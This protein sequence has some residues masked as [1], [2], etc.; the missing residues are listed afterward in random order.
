MRK[1][2]LGV[3]AALLAGACFEDPV[4]VEPGMDG[5]ASGSG[6]GT[7]PTTHTAT[8]PDTDAPPTTME[9]V[10][11]SVDDTAAPDESSTGEPLPVQCGDGT[12]V[13]GELCYD[14][15]TVLMAN[16]VTF[17]ARIGDVSS[18][19]ATDVVHLISDQVVVRAGNGS[20]NFGPAVFDASVVA[21]RFELVDFDGDGE[22]DVLAAETSGRLH[23]L[24]GTGAGSFA[25][26]D[27][28]S[29]GPDPQALAV[30]DLDGDGALDAVVGSGT[31]IHV[32]LGDG[33]GGLGPGTSLVGTSPVTGLSLGDVDGDAVLDLALAI[34]GGDGQGVVLRRGVGDGTFA[35]Q[36]ATPGRLGGA[37]AIVAGDLDGDGATDLAYVSQ[38]SQVVG[39]LLG[40]EDGLGPEL[41][42]PTG[43]GPQ[44]LHAADLDGDG[45]L[46]LVV[47]HQGETT[48][49]VFTVSAGGVAEALQIPLASPATALHSG[50]VNG[51][52]VPDLAATSSAAH[53][54]T[55]VLSTP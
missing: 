41:V 52:A 8:G 20:G 15:T 5:T 28:E 39:V 55:L 9:P 17:S 40:G 13:V 25:S 32:V 37:R 19:P 45:R 21:R 14:D 3:L 16:D 6:T 47:A 1:R 38:E 36:E 10:S 43:S 11:T 44:A 42:A 7:G 53:I 51:D 24:L 54:V 31:M 23:L 12:A 29:V 49:R 48:L 46:E 34:D 50:D 33:A 4:H 26:Q 27:E 35:E 18:T 22:L 30:G 2:W